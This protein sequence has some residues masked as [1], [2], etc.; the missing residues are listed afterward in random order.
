MQIQKSATISADAS[1][2]GINY[3]IV[4]FLGISF[5]P[6]IKSNSEMVPEESFIN[7]I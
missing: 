5:P 3:I 1:V 2:M 4:F 6:S 7:S